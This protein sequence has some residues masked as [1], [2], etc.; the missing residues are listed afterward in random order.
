MR[1]DHH[2]FQKIPTVAA[3]SGETDVVFEA[4]RAGL[5][6]FTFSAILPQTTWSFASMLLY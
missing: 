6:T 4:S 1:F 2:C 3:E 5:G